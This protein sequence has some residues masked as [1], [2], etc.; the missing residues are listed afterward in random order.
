MDGATCGPI[1][2]SPPI[3]RKIYVAHYPR[4]GEMLSAQRILALAPKNAD[5]ETI[6]LFSVFGELQEAVYGWTFDNDPAIDVI[7]ANLTDPKQWPELRK[8]RPLESRD[9][10]VSIEVGLL[11]KEYLTWKARV[12]PTDDELEKYYGLVN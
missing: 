3:N 11:W 7:K 4:A 2:I 10:R 1:F 6:Q 9:P 12:T 8:F 5:E